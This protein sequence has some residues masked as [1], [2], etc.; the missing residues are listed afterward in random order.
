MGKDC[1]IKSPYE[2]KT[3]VPVKTDK[4]KTGQF[5]VTTTPV[6]VL[7]SNPDRIAVAFTNNS[8]QSVFVG[9]DPSVSVSIPLGGNNPG[10]EL[11][12]GGTYD[13]EHYTGEYWMCVA[14]GS[15]YISFSEL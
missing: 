8:T 5:L 6:R 2:V 12:V 14:S 15:S 4:G 9:F 3:V 1:K 10:Q 11:L 7:R 13:D